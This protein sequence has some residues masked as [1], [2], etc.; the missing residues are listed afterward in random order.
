M[1][2]EHEHVRDV[3]AV[4]VIDSTVRLVEPQDATVIVEILPA[5]VEREFKGVPIRAR[6]LGQGWPPRT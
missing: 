1:N 3:V 6:N 4:G 5:P 2:G